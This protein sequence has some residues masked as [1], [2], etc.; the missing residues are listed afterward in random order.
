[1]KKSSENGG[2]TGHPPGMLQ[3][4]SRELSKA[5][6]SK[7][8]AMRQ[9]LEA[10]EEIHSCG[11]HCHRPACIKAQRDALRE[12]VFSE[13]ALREVKYLTP[14]RL[15]QELVK[16]AR[17][18]EAMGDAMKYLG[19]F[20]PMFSRGAELLGAADLVREWAGEIVKDQSNV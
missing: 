5:L 6:A 20:G 10:A 11:Y 3:D 12:T 19:G 1:M 16:L 18:M 8:D 7:P 13:Y 15:A 2:K 4:D 9:A 14:E 17:Q